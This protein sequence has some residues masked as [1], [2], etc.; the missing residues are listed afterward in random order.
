MT[1]LKVPALVRTLAMLLFV[2]LL[3][4]A[5]VAQTRTEA[6]LQLQIQEL[7]EQTIAKLQATEKK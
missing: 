3:P 4:G 2:A 7:Q 1:L 5:A 6:Q